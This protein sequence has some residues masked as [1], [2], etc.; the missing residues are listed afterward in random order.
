M[1]SM[2]LVSSRVEMTDKMVCFASF[3]LWPCFILLAALC[4]RMQVT[5]DR[6]ESKAMII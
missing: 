5:M 3:L 1:Q 4:V 6:R 2:N